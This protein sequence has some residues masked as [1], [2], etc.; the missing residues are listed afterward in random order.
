MSRMAR[1]LE[2]VNGTVKGSL[3]LDDENSPL[4]LLRRQLLDVITQ[5]EKSNGQ[6][7]TEI[8]ETVAALKARKQEKARS[9]RHGDDFQEAIGEFKKALKLRPWFADIITQLGTAYRDSGDFENAIETFQKAIEI[10][11]R[12][13]PAVINLG[14]TYY[15]MGFV[16]LALKEWKNALDVDPENRDAKVYISIVSGARP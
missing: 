6:F 8:R 4:S 13:L 3:T 1:L 9:T 5:I 15:M 16:D 12:H 2:T 11:H 10:N 7:H 14:I